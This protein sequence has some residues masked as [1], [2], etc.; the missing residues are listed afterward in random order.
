MD[1]VYDKNTMVYQL[2]I[3]L[4]F[5]LWYNLL[6]RIYDFA[7]FLV[8][9]FCLN[10]TLLLCRYRMQFLVIYASGEMLSDNFG[11]RLFRLFW[12][13]LFIILSRKL[14]AWK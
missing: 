13:C 10:W 5:W 12:I 1:F 14:P 6:L 4:F 9:S 2:K 3:Y 11:P 8:I 7:I